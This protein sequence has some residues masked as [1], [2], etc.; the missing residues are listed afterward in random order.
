MNTTKMN[1]LIAIKKKSD[2]SVKTRQSFQEEWLQLARTEGLTYDIMK[3]F[4]D[5]FSFA[6]AAPLV[7]YIREN[8][9]AVTEV[10]NFFKNY[11]YADKNKFITSKLLLHIL[12]LFLKILP[13][14]HE[15]IKYAIK[16]LPFYGKD[17][18][19]GLVDNKTLKKY[20]IQELP[21]DLLYPK[22]EFY[23]MEP[24]FKSFYVRIMKNLESIDNEKEITESEEKVINNVI[25]W[26]SA[27]N[28]EDKV[29]KTADTSE[30]K[31]ETIIHDTEKEQVY[32]N[33]IIITAN[34]LR[35][36][37]ERLRSD[38]ADC[39]DEKTKLQNE[40]AKENNLYL[41]ERN[42]R[43][44]NTLELSQANEK[45][46]HLS[47]VVKN[48]ENQIISKDT[49]IKSRE[50]QSDILLRHKDDQIV[51]AMNR[52][53]GDLEIEYKDFLTAID[54]PMTVD[55]GENMREQLKSVFLLLKKHGVR[56][57]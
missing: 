29:G 38:F 22:I 33:N 40:L 55:L 27:V 8:E 45:I 36:I 4:Y 11:D 5:G 53:S 1:E 9:A 47:A 56:L 3:Y 17:E 23:D 19:G 35:K 48:Q 16:K 39:N 44:K 14:K 15:I 21:D 28:K 26:L 46:E 30:K 7:N 49:E 57:E 34:D 2:A 6:G 54:C 24:Y 42:E 31:K 20:F 43:Q 51:I 18:N 25:G 32:I 41:Q 10:D 52:I 12:A 37:I 13:E 50:K